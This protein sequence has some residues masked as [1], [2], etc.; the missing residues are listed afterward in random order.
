MNE[1]CRSAAGGRLKLSSPLVGRDLGGV[2][3]L[4]RSSGMI[5]PRI[6]S[7]LIE[8]FSKC[9]TNPNKMGVMQIAE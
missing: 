3:G 4:S 2:R 8:H 1:C 5:T 7:L 9:G 6:G